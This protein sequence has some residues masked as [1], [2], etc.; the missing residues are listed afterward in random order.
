MAS[1]YLYVAR[2]R[3]KL[4]STTE[5]TLQ[6]KNPAV[7]LVAGDLRRQIIRNDAHTTF[8]SYGERRTVRHGLQAVQRKESHP[9]AKERFISP[10]SRKVAFRRLQITSRDASL[11][12]LTGPV[13]HKDR[14]K[15]SLARITSHHPSGGG[16]DSIWIVDVFQY[17]VA[18]NNVE[19]SRGK[20]VRYL[21]RV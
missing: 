11:E 9:A 10:R 19:R 1:D 14:Y 13:A 7:L 8:H 6:F 18:K 16:E 21:R 20:Q 3:R 4:R 2:D 12:H 5:P 17:V 15:P